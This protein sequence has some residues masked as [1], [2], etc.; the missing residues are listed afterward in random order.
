MRIDAVEVDGVPVGVTS[1]RTIDYLSG[2]TVSLAFLD[3][4]HAAEGTQIDIVWGPG[5]SDDTR[6]RGRVAPMP[7]YRGEFR[8]ETYEPTRTRVEQEAPESA[9]VG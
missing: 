3:A 5:G 1:G 6:I 8:N 2:R 4:A 9:P 7:Y